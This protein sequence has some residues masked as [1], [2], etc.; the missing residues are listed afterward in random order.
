MTHSSNVFH[1]F[2]LPALA[3]IEFNLRFVRR[4]RV[5]FF[6]MTSWHHFQEGVEGSDPLQLLELILINF[7]LI[8]R[9]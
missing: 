8:S 6:G 9:Y 1:I 5:V 7:S 2:S 3:A 4:F